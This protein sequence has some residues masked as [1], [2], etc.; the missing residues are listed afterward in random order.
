MLSTLWIFLTANY[1][2]CDLLSNMEAEVL[3]GYLAG[4]VG[5]MSVTQ[6]FLLGAA[7]F[8]E[9]PFAMIFLTRVLSYRASR[10][11]NIVAGGVMA[12]A[13][14][15]SFFVGT[16]M[17][18]HYWFYSIVEIACALYIAWRALRWMPEAEIAPVN[19]GRADEERSIK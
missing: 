17:T 18:L 4:S 11:A 16:P 15:A 12:A 1:I 7:A 13:Q 19:S 9:I 8:M 3:K 5:G 6:Q 14:V 2:Y 10:W